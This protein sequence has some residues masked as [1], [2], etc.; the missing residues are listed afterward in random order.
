MT[1]TEV[2][3][4]MTS[5]RNYT[6]ALERTI[7]L[8]VRNMSDADYRAFLARVRRAGISNAFPGA[9]IGVRSI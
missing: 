5:T 1:L 2:S 7:Q 9:A 8:A 4:K 3:Q 6:N